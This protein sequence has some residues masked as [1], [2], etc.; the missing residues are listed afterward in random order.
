[1]NLT[2]VKDNDLDKNKAYYDKLE[3]NG[4]ESSQFITY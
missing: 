4:I 2:Y 1:M 3:M